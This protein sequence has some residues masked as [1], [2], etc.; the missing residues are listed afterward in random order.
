MEV[1]SIDITSL[2]SSPENSFR[3]EVG[4]YTYLVFFFW[5]IFA[6]SF[7]YKVSRKLTDFQV[8]GSEKPDISTVAVTCPD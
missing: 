2:Q 3:A 7:K 8:V 5:V 4:L 1:L 6:P